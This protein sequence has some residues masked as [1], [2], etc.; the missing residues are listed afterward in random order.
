MTGPRDFSQCSRVLSSRWM[1]PIL[2]TL[3]GPRRFCDIQSE[4]SGL[5]RGVLAA[6]LQELRD[7]QLLHQQKYSCFPPRVE[8]Q[9][10]EKGQALMNT[11][12]ILARTQFGELS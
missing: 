2:C 3:E 1:V 4:L 10:T 6:Q 5:S 11:L 12:Q 7:M 8:Y 9:L